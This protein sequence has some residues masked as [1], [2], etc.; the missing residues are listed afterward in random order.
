MTHAIINHP[1]IPIEVFEIGYGTLRIW[2][3][4]K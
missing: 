2:D 3:G 4:I 1:H